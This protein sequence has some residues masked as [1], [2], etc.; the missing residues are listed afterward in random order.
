MFRKIV[1]HLPFSPSLINELGFYAKRLS[2]EEATRKLGLIFTVLALIVQSL[3]VFSPPESANAADP[4]DMVRGGVWSGSQMMNHYDANT[5]D[6]RSLFDTIG[7]TRAELSNAT[8]NLQTLHSRDGNYSWGMTP[9][10]GSAQGEGSYSVKSAGSGMRNFYYR[11]HQLW[12]N[13]TYTA[14]VGHSAKF[15]WFAIMRNCGNLITKSIPPAPTCPPGQIGTY[16]N[17][18]TPPAPIVTCNALE[19]KQGDNNKYQF[20]ANTS[21]ANGATIQKYV[22]NVYRGNS[23]VKTLESTTPDVTYQEKT[24]GSYKVTVTLKTS[25]GDRTSTGCQKTFNIAEP[26]RCPQN[27]TLLKDDP[28]CQP[29]AGN[30]TLW[31]EDKQCS[32]SFIQQKNAINLT[33]SNMDATKTTAK[34]QDRIT[35]HLKVTNKGFAPEKYTFTENLGDVLQYSS[36]FESG[37][38]TLKEDANSNGGKTVLQW[39]EVTIKPGETQER[40]FTIQMASKISS[41]STGTSNPGS[42]DCRMD[43]TFG[44]TVSVKVDCPNEKKVVETVATQLPRTGAGENM[45]FAGLILSIVT[46]FYLRSRQLKKEVRIIRHTYNS[47][48]T[49]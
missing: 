25:L 14:Y 49:I 19:I 27:P 48:G 31:I 26:E 44:N 28:R 11:P 7:I 8:R 5:N 12:G 35:Y 17:C 23:L 29:C 40:T 37:G 39:P 10:F 9:H 3:V 32:A 33:Q 22:F 24:P 38:G 43:N 41:M 1:S 16:P 30:P 45:L 18:S 13:F 6:I 46:F 4:S 34:A 36:I 47:V 15:G 20:T 21:A 42:F 2:K